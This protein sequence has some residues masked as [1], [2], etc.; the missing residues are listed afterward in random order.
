[1]TKAVLDEAKRFERR[2]KRAHRRYGIVA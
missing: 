1:M 2:V